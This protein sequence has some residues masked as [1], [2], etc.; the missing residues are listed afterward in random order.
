MQK[1]YI[2]TGRMTD[3]RTV[4]LD[5]ALPGPPT[6]VRLV[7]E[8]LPATVPAE[9]G[10]YRAVLEA[11]RERQRA[12]GHRPPTREEVDAQL[13]AERDSWGDA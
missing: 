6:R 9:A 7:V 10:G 4:V 2:V 3:D 11:I 12:R 13:Q 5:E 1:A 8:S